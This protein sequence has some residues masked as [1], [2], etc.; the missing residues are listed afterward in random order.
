[1]RV[2]GGELAAIFAGGGLGALARVA[3]A[4]ALPPEPGAWPW[5]TF[6][7]NVAGALVLAWVAERVHERRRAA[8]LGTGLCGALTTFSA[9][10]LELL[11]M[12][13]EAYYE[14]AA[15]YAVASVGAGIG[16]VAVATAVARRRPA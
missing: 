16:A 12:L 11:L 10:Q 3:L 2:D 14:L 6:L 8:L 1:V 4:E 9:L 15:G 5:A 13:E 7:V